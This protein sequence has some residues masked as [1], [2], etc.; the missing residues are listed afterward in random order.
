MK[1]FFFQ[2]PIEFHLETSEN[3]WTQGSTI[4]GKLRIKNSGNEAVEI[5]NIHVGVIYGIFKKIKA[6]EEDA[7]G[8]AT[9]QILEPSLQLG[10]QEE[11]SFQWEYPLASNC[12]IT[13]KNGGLFLVYG[14]QASD[15]RGRIDLKVHLHT[16]LQSFIQTFETQFRFQKKYEKFKDDCTEIKFVPPDSK[17]FPTLDHLLCFLKIQNNTMEI[18]YRFK[19]KSLGKASGEDIVKVRNKK[20]EIQQSYTAEQYERG[21]FPNRDCFRQ[22]I[23]EALEEAQ[24]KVLF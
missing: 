23:S 2:R 6:K 11:K 16:M 22:A 1:G 7:W 19:M 9:E 10:A 24:P 17:N 5:P 15:E 13:D 14:S 12:P 20:K 3:E 4:Q 21:G 8:E 18:L